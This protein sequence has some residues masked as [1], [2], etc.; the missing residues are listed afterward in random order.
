MFQIHRTTSAVICAATITAVFSLS[1]CAEPA[2][3][4]NSAGQAATSSSTISPSPTADPEPVTTTKKATKKEAIPFEKVTKKNPNLDEG[5]KRVTTKGVKG[6]LTKTFRVTYVDG[7]E[8]ERKLVKE[9]VTKKPVNQ[10]T[11]IGT[12]R[13]P[14]LPEPAEPEPSNCDPN[15]SGCVPIASDVDC[16]GGSGDG[17]EYVNGP[18]RVTGSDIYGL[19]ADGNGVGCE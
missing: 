17:P 10:V 6:V 3:T 15:Y 19:D 1:G 8:T 16:A 5:T 12:H 18:V 9:V 14:P 2:T 13:P 4:D 7:E 11:S